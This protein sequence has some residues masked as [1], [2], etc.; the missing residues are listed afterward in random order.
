MVRVSWRGALLCGAVW[1][2]TMGPRTALAYCRTTNA[3]HDQS[4]CPEACVTEG[5]PLQWQSP[6][7]HYSLHPRGFP[8]LSEAQVRAVFAEA[9]G[10]WEEVV[11]G[12][13]PVG[14]QIREDEQTTDDGVGP[15]SRFPEWN[16]NTMVLLNAQEWSDHD[17]SDLAFA[18]TG[19]WFSPRTGY[20]LGADMQFN[21]AMSRFGNCPDDGCP[22]DGSLVDLRNVATHEAGH[23]LGLAH[24]ED[25][26]STMWCG[27][28]TRDLSKR[29]LASDDIDGLCAAYP[30]G[31]ALLAGPP[32]VVSSSCAL[33]EG[34]GRVA[35]GPL[36][37]LILAGAGLCRRRR[38]TPSR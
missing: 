32:Y 37:L 4:S 31:Q 28:D 21:G 1:W 29:D 22:L 38:R 2:G 19:V 12:S 10:T 9:F 6:Y 25:Q 8:G 30:P 16:V 18:V 14:F 17:F 15:E 24:S 13:E 27:A 35:L 34:A 33:V 5:T 23:F 7:L 26:N 3:K 20:I 36:W 11:C